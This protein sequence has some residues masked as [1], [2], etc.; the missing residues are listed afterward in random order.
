MKVEA[1]RCSSD[2]RTKSARSAGGTSCIRRLATTRSGRVS[3]KARPRGA[4][5]ESAAGK[6]RRRKATPARYDGDQRVVRHG[7]TMAPRAAAQTVALVYVKA[8]S[9]TPT[10][11]SNE[12]RLP[13]TKPVGARFQDRGHLRFSG[14]ISQAFSVLSLPDA[15]LPKCCYRRIRRRRRP[16]YRVIYQHRPPNSR[17]M[18][19]A[20]Q[21]S[22][23]IRE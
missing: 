11:I 14:R 22:S 2:R 23:S 3:S 19:K 8:G 13:A 21:R 16:A 12:L 17:C 15:K 4:R 9:M 5:F 6:A 18:S 7:A 1:F 20:Y 10:R